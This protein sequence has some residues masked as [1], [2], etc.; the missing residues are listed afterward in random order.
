MS[1]L[2]R[3]RITTAGINILGILKHKC[4]IKKQDIQPFITIMITKQKRGKMSFERVCQ[5]YC[6]LTK[7]PATNFDVNHLLF[8]SSR[9]YV[10]EAFCAFVESYGWKMYIGFPEFPNGHSNIFASYYG[11]HSSSYAFLSKKNLIPSCRLLPRD[12][13]YDCILATIPR[14]SQTQL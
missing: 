3:N 8:L 11:D 5:M 6:S 10:V 1:S 2:T 9:D 4:K 14:M 13:W 12:N 7:W